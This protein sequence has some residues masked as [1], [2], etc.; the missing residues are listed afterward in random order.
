MADLV[1]GCTGASAERYAATPTLSFALTIT[2]S[3][4][5]EVHA[6]AETGLQ[7]AYLV[8]GSADDFRVGL[9]GGSRRIIFRCG[10]AFFAAIAAA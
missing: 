10:C 4:G 7:Q 5:A 8:A 9:R 1:F 2:E 3:T 6:I